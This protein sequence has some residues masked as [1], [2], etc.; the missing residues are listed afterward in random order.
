MRE[1]R[2]EIYSPEAENLAVPGLRDA[3]Q[4]E[5]LVVSDLRPERYVLVFPDLPDPFLDRA[6][7]KHHRLFR[8]QYSYPLIPRALH[9]PLIPAPG[10]G[11]RP[12][13]L[14]SGLSA[15]ASA[16]VEA[17][18]EEG[19][20]HPV[21]SAKIANNARINYAKTASSLENSL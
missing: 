11:A 17:L 2:E 14:P 16:K 20:I 5:S 18:A 3:D 21:R 19:P 15:E 8:G 6:G 1:V 7:S 10:F 9:P 12:T 4:R 13:C